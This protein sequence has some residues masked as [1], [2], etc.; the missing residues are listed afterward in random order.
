MPRGRARDIAPEPRVRTFDE[1]FA[2]LHLTPAERVALVWQLAALRFR[3]TIETLL[4][5]TKHDFDP[6]DH[7]LR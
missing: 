5:E 2:E 6:R 4:P 7:G 3:K 1:V